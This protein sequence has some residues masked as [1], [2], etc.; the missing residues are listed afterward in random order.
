M[1]GISAGQ[2]QLRLIDYTSRSPPSSWSLG[3]GGGAVHLVELSV[4]EGGSVAFI[5]VETLLELLSDLAADG[6]QLLLD[7]TKVPSHQDDHFHLRLGR[8]GGRSPLRLEEADLAKKVPRPEV[9]NVLTLLPY[10]SSPLHDDEELERVLTLEGQDLVPGDRHFLSRLRDLEE[11]FFA[12]A[13]EYGDSAEAV[14]IHLPD[15][16]ARSGALTGG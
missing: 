5:I 13:T 10:R 8:D 16:F 9:T 2:G 14:Q 11:F 1:R 7:L 12:E 3:A 6:G 4:M 15:P